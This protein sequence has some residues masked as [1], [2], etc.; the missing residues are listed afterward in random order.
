MPGSSTTMRPPRPVIS[1]AAS[2]AGT[3]PV[4]SSLTE[5]I[6]SSMLGSILL[7]IALVILIIGI[8]YRSVAAGLLGVIPMALTIL[9]NF[10]VMGLTGIRLDISTAMVGSISIGIGIDYCIHFLSGYTRHFRE[11]G[12]AAG[13]TR[14]T[15]ES[16]GKAILFNAASV[17][18]GFAV[19]IFSRF[20]PL[21]YLGILV[22]L[23]MVVSSLASLTLLP[24]LLNV[25]KPRFLNRDSSTQQKKELIA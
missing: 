15:M 6:V 3:A 14:L 12:D 9:V 19:L 7:S 23:T 20:N 18:A 5:L 22:V 8:T 1:S 16:S 17:A 21:M 4:Q 10:G 24:A 11:A 25:L 2:N 13:A